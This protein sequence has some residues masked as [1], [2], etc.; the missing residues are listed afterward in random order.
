M[1]SSQHLNRRQ[2]VK[3]ATALTG[4]LMLPRIPALAQVSDSLGT[5][6]PKRPLG[7]TGLQVTVY[8]VGGHH[9]GDKTDSVAQATIERAI[10][11][12]VRF[13]DTA[14]SYQ[15]GH[16]ET[17]IGRYLTP[18]MREQSILLTKTKA[19]DGETAAKDIRD[20]LQRLRTDW[21]DVYLIHSV[22]SISDIERRLERGVYDAI[23]DAKKQGLIHHVGFS[24]HVTPEANNHLIRKQ[25]SDMEIMLCPVNVADPSYKSFILESLPIAHEYG[26]GV[27]AMKS[28]AGGGLIGG[29]SVW[30]RLRGQERPSIVPGLVSVED[31]Q[32]FSLSQ[33]VA[34]LVAGH[35]TIEQLETNIRVARDAIR[36]TESEREELISR[37]AHIAVEGQNEHYKG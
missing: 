31:A 12:G 6:L 28:L 24:G 2:F 14:E 30:G 11:M 26:L 27:L 13:F 1:R 3:T 5:V 29:R 34:S 22:N 10:E 15:R 36:M 8:C 25:L 16:S 23:L 18:K 35:D 7:K 33:P 17:L 9:I 19:I 4:A 20:S 32:R 21:I 37:V